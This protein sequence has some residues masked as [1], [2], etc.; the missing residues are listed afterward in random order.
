MR[1]WWSNIPLMRF[2]TLKSPTPLIGLAQLHQETGI[3]ITLPSS[4][5]QGV[6]HTGTGILDRPKVHLSRMTADVC[7]SHLLGMLICIANDLKNHGQDQC[8]LFGCAWSRHHAVLACRATS[9]HCWYT[10]LKLLSAC[11]LHAAPKVRVS[12]KIPLRRYNVDPAGSSS[13]RGPRPTL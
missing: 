9:I 13:S 7:N 4:C 6:Q 11:P 10:L 1:C 5:H 12:V 2:S 8:C 3:S